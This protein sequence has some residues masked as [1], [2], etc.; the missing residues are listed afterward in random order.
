MKRWK[1]TNL[2]VA[3]ALVVASVALAKKV[4][5]KGTEGSEPAKAE[6]PAAPPSGAGPDMRYWNGE[7]RFEFLYG[8]DWYA[9]EQRAGSY[10]QR[11]LSVPNM[12]SMPEIP[13]M[14]GM[15][16]TSKMPSRPPISSITMPRTANVCFATKRNCESKDPVHD[17]MARLSIVNMQALENMVSPSMRRQLAQAQAKAQAPAEAPQE[18]GSQCDTLENVKK[19]WGGENATWMAMRCP[20]ED[21]WRYSVTVSM[22]RKAMRGQDMYSLMCT[23]RS[24]SK[25]K[26][27][28]LAEFR[29]DLKPRCEKIVSTTKFIP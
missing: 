1:M 3:C 16:S 19:K 22:Q 7:Y 20:E 10:S 27:G 8:G 28:S 4:E 24:K 17:P 6:V 29:G 21:A 23:M 2:I 26:E 12:P 15:P 18:A 13:S 14:P 5:T 11:T 9:S 25:D